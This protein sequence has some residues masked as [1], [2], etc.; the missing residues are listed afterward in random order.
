[1]P[2]HNIGKKNKH[3]QQIQIMQI[4]NSILRRIKHTT[5]NSDIS[6]TLI[7]ELHI[8]TNN[9]LIIHSPLYHPKFA[10]VTKHTTIYSA[11]KYSIRKKNQSFPVV[12][13]HEDHNP[14]LIPY[15]SRSFNRSRGNLET[16]LEHLEVVLLVRSQFLNGT[17]ILQESYKRSGGLLQS[18]QPRHDLHPPLHHIYTQQSNTT[19]QINKTEVLIKENAANETP[20][21]IQ[22]KTGF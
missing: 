16:L 21:K 19:K 20:N 10:R 12:T 8:H 18:L 14:K 22:N 4:T 1:M 2:K 9:R 3:Y 13:N 6:D 17:R 7:Q 11:G 5:R 15:K